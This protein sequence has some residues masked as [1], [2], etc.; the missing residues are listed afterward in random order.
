MTVVQQLQFREEV[1][2]EFM[3][4]RTGAWRRRAGKKRERTG[5]IRGSG[6]SFME[7]AP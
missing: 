1:R 3:I 5:S 2:E 7:T 6:V 4:D